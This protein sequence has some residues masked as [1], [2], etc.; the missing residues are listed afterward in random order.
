[1]PPAGS[2]ATAGCATDITDRRALEQ[3]LA[4]LG[5]TGEIAQLAGGIAH[6]FNN[7]LTGIL[8]H[9]TLLLDESSLSPEAREDLAQIRQA[10]DRAAT[11]SRHLLAFSRRPQLA[12]RSLDLNQLVGGTMS[13]IRQMVGTR[14]RG[15]PRAGG[16]TRAGAGRSRRSS[17]R[18]CSSSART[19]RA[20]MPG[21]GR[22]QPRDRPGRGGRREG[23]EPPGLRPGSYVTLEISHIGP[24]LD[25]EALARL[26]DPPTGTSSGEPLPIS[27]RSPGSPGR[28]GATSPWRAQ[29]KRA[30][31]SYALHPPARSG[32]RE[33][34]RASPRSTRA[35]RRSC[36]SKTSC[37]CA[38]SPA[39]RSSGR[40]TPCSPPATRRRRSRSPTGIRVTSTC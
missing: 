11:L 17:S 8:G 9:V 22:L 15:Q 19:R 24:A 14:G 2:S 38:T 29:P 5:R 35:P 7:L 37:R 27:P 6:D 39:A 26:F 36:W 40:D 1:M 34:G 13:A 12:P 18:S 25:P 23:G 20:A 33:H 3:R 4:E 32:G 16:W 21:G 28:A 10:A 31:P 30:P